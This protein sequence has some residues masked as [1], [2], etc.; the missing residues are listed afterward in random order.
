MRIGWVRFMSSNAYRDA[1]GS[2]LDGGLPGG[3]QKL[4]N[5]CILSADSSIHDEKEN[6]PAQILQ[7]QGR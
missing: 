4:E 3:C 5:G 1:A 6:I 7:P 2:S